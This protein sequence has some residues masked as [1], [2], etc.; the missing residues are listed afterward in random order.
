MSLDTL[1]HQQNAKMLVREGIVVVIVALAMFV[2]WDSPGGASGTILVF[3]AGAVMV[4][5][6]LIMPARNLAPVPVDSATD[7]DA[8]ARQL[9]LLAGRMMTN[10]MIPTFAGLLAGIISGGWQ[11]VVFGA[12]ISIAGFTFFGPSRTRLAGWRERIE[13]AGGKTGL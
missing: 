10:V 8:A 3:L 4:A 6:G 5:R 11:P 7:P 2:I 9:E 1:A 12:L 13:S